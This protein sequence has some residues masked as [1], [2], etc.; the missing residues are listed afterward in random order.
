M[1]RIVQNSHAGGAKSYYSTAD[2][3][4][5]GQELQ[6]VWCGKGAQRLGLSGPVGRPAWDALCD[7]RH[8]GTGERLTPRQKEPRRVGYDFNFHVP[9]SVSLLYGLTQDERILDAFRASVRLTMQDMEAEVQARVR[10]GGRNQDRTTGNMV[11]GEFV[12][13]TARPVDGVPDP[14]L[15]AHCFVFNTTWDQTEGRW[16]AGQFAGLKRDAP[17]F[18]A[19]F[20]AHLARR[21]VD[22][23]LPVQRTKSGWELG[24]LPD[25][26]LQKVSRRTAQ[27]E[28]L[29]RQR[30]ITD[31]VLKD[32]LG[33]RTRQRKAKHLGL[34]DLRREWRGRLT[35]AEQAAVEALAARVGS[36]A[37]PE[38]SGARRTAVSLAISH[39]FE[40]RSVVPERVLQGEA[41]RR[42]AGV[43]SVGEVLGEVARKGLI[44]AERGGQRVVTTREVLAEERAILDFAR[45]GRGSQAPL[46]DGQHVFKREWLNV[47]QRK[48]VL[49][50]LGSPDR[51]ILVRG[52]AGVGKTSLMQEAVEAIQAN[53][54]RV[55]T[56]APSA[57]ASRGTLRQEG[58][59]N[60]DTVA[61]LLVDQELQSC[62]RDQVIWVDE[63]G[64]LGTRTMHDL[65]DVAE[66]AHARVVLSG[67]RAQHKSV[68]RGDALRLLEE[69]A[70]LVSQEVRDI[71]RQK[72]AYKEA[73]AALSEGRVAEG[74]QRLDRLGWIRQEEDAG[75]RSAAL[76]RDYAH[77]VA[78]GKSVLVV[79]P[80]H[81]EGEAITQSIRL[82]LTRRGR[83]GKA[84]RVYK[85]LRNT[86]MT[87]A[88]RAD[89]VN[90]WPGDVIVYTQN[91][92][93]HSR[94]ERVEVTARPSD[95]SHA[96]RFGV[97]RVHAIE[98]AA[99][100]RIRV[101]RNGT[102]ADGQH[103]LNNGAIYTVRGFTPGGDLRLE[104]GWVVG[105]D[106]GHI[107]H[108]YCTTSH[109]AQG[110]TVDVALLAQSSISL[111]ASSQEQFY[112]SASRAR[113]RTIVYCDDK[114]QLMEAV[115]HRGDRTSA[116]ELVS[117]R[118]ERHRAIVHERLAE[119]ER[120]SSPASRRVQARS[121]QEVAHER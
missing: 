51:V 95:L 2:Y 70:G 120:M 60:A 79:S 56:F 80:T 96:E 113:E 72:G 46:G 108:G 13:L 7:N 106:W 8:P 50:V 67:D 89:S 40:R 73:V 68:E 41:L 55:F 6:G 26:A 75:V 17:Y 35:A 63:A 38:N 9:K 27:I 81:R 71:Q 87:A 77:A 52:A 64:L 112:V 29:A 30:G 28:E 37:E 36:D 111:R 15:H 85:V 25:S 94:G 116:T 83:L 117:S 22:L 48:A 16:K 20:H 99:G 53:G 12:H 88:E 118:S 42:A 98:L 3:Y 1:L 47:G 44:N 101:T 5:Q 69:E 90:Y 102:T 54:K 91:A 114:G 93:G 32:E 62:V 33:A 119:Q 65:F 49:H 103:R 4:T 39:C 57:D 14:H 24:G 78:A 21:L 109:S 31:A 10:V 58:F 105:Q 11:W 59:D 43:A 84:R 86:H 23:G 45:L 107:E 110:R 104:N 61:R 121:T 18:E 19:L 76:A 100:D 97:Y 34:D 66:R 115:G 82:E 92:P 74:F